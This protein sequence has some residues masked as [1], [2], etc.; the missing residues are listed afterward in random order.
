MLAHADRI[1]IVGMGG[2]FPGSVDVAAF[3]SLVAA[4]RD[5]SADVPE[6]RWAFAPSQVVG[7]PLGTADRVPHARGY[8]LPAFTPQLQGLNLRDWPLAELDPVFQLALHIGNT[9]W[10][11]AK[12]KDVANERCGVIFGNIALPTEQT[13]AITRGVFGPRF[14]LTSLQQPSA[15]NLH[16]AGLPAALLAKALGFGLGGFTLDAA[17]ASSLYAIKLACDELLS[18]RADAMLA[19][20][21]SRPDCLYTQMGFAQLKALSASGRCSPFDAAADGLVVG[22]GGC[23][24]VLKRLAD[25]EAQGDTILGVIAGIGLSNDVEGNL[26][27][28]ASEGQL[29]AMRSAYLQANW[30]PSDV[31]LIECHATGTPTGDAVEFGSLRALWDDQSGRAV[32]GCVKSSVGH[33]LTG[34][35]SAGL[36]KVLLAIKHQTL[37]PTAN[38]KQPSPKMAYANGPFR[39]LQQAE[40]WNATTRRAAVSAFGFGGINAHLLVE[41]YTPTAAATPQISVR[42]GSNTTPIAIVGVA[43]LSGSPLSEL[44]LPLTRFRIPPKELE[45]TLPQQTLML[46]VATDAVADVQSTP[47]DPLALGVF[48]GMTLDPNTSNFHLRWAADEQQP[49]IKDAVH[50][51]LNANR[52]MGALASIAA[53]R[54][55]RLLGAGGPSFSLSD[56]Q[57]GGLRALSLA[58]NALQEGEID[59]AIVGAVDLTTD[60]RWRGT[61]DGAAAVVLKRLADATRDGDRIYGTLGELLPQSQESVPSPN[62]VQGLLDVVTACKTLARQETT[63]NDQPA[64][65]IHD[66]ANGR[67]R[68]AVRSTNVAGFG[69]S[70]EIAE[71]PPRRSAR[72]EQPELASALFT[73]TGDTTEHLLAQMNSRVSLADDTLHG[74]ARQWWQHTKNEPRGKLG[75]AFVA[76][77]FDEYRQAIV[78]AR[79]QLVSNTPKMSDGVC[80]SHQP[81]KGKVAFVYPGSGNHFPDMGRE[82]GRALPHVLHRQMLENQR[83]ASQYHATQVWGVPSLAD[84]SPRDLIFAQ[85]SLGTLVSDL[86]ASFGVKPQAAVGYSLGESASMYGTRAWRDRDEMFERMSVSSLFTSDLAGPCNAARQ[87]WQFGDRDVVDWTTGV[88]HASADKVRAAL[89]PNMRAYLLIINTDTDCVIGGQRA[90]VLEL[91][92]KLNTPLLEVQGVTTAHCEVAQPVRAP[93]RTL[94]HLPTTPPEGVR[95]YSG[96]WGHSYD[97]TADSA[98]DAITAAVLQTIDFPKTVRH[99]YADGARIFIEIGPGQSCTRMIASILDQQPHMVHAACVARQE[100]VAQFLNLL[101]QLHAEGVALNLDV[102]YGQ[103]TPNAPKTGPTLKVPVGYHPHGIAREPQ[104]DVFVP[105]AIPV[106]VAPAG[107]MADALTASVQAHDAFL[108]FTTALQAAFAQSVTWQTALMQQA[109]VADFAHTTPTVV[110]LPTAVPRSLTLEQCNEFAVGK[111]GRVLG[112]LFA[113]IDEHPTRVR[114]PEGPLQLV[115]RIVQIDGEPKSLSHGRVVTEHHVHADRWYLDAGRI[116][117]CVAVEAGQADLFL[118]GFLGIDF[119]TKGLACYRLLDAT[120]TFHRPLP[121]VGETIRYDIHIDSFF[122]QGQ[123]YLFRFHFESTVNGE[124]LLSMREGCA[125]F[126]TAQELASGKGIIHTTLDKKPLPG[127]VP[128][129]WSPYVPLVEQSFSES[130]LDA[131]RQGQLM[132]AFGAEFDRAAL[133][134]PMPLPGGMLKL[135]HRI[136]RILPTGG[137]YGLGQIR[138]EADIHPDDW[139]LTCHFV[140]DQVMPGTLMYECCMHTLRVLLMRMGFVGERGEYVHEPLPGIV[141][142]LKCRGQVIASTK[143][144]TYEVSLKEIGFE[145]SAYVLADALMYADGK[146]IVEIT[147]MS[148]RMTG[149]SRERL[150]AIWHRDPH[151]ALFDT[152]SILAFAIGKPS[153]AFGERYRIFDQERVIARLPGPPY[154]FLDRITSIKHCEPWKLAAG[155]EIIAEYDVPPEEWYFEANRCDKMP[156]SVLLEV[157]LQPCG[158]LAAYLGSALTSTKDLSFRN[159]GGTAT[160]FAEV[161]PDAGTLTTKVKITKVSSSGGMIIQHYDYAVSCA[162][163]PVYV[164]NTYFGFFSKDALANQVGLKDASLMEMGSTELFGWKGPLPTTSPFPNDMLRMVDDIDWCTTA[165]GPQGLGTISGR[166]KVKPDAWFFKAHFH[167]DPVWPGSLGLESF[168]QLLKLFAQRR[169]GKPANG[170]Q[171]VALHRPHQWVYRGQILPTDAEVTVQAYITHIDDATRLVQANGLLSVDGR[172]IYQMTDFAITG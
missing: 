31:S 22:E 71:G 142:R 32:I 150:N 116:P 87:Q 1:A 61:T 9:A 107:T 62:A 65:W 167:Q 112:P 127:V 157:A 21:L 128:T 83:L 159:L 130:Q 134:S 19:G 81:L 164:G 105:S 4:G 96:A 85:V 35:G 160:Q 41:E 86:L 40:P 16:A 63:I 36:A 38:F 147:N 98:A 123:T 12:T 102:L 67:R 114:L 125:G 5:A 52:T 106:P 119:V 58:T 69:L 80:F 155:G 161:R 34:A 20:G 132:R 72:L 46:Q 15:L 97:L 169:L 118:S 44:T 60:E 50:Q 6:R 146:P 92:R 122:R 78:E 101:A 11:S 54:I 49:A 171:A 165:S 91:A 43:S 136:E 30:K 156:F 126:F 166:A 18:G 117:T 88:V 131:L 29:R 53:S 48:I 68:V 143:K 110:E 163:K 99:A 144:V 8:Y 23:A 27:L 73:L 56:E 76:S 103:P 108:R 90:D 168:I 135:V 45:E 28:P 133:Q 139:F 140:D 93:Y 47:G 33:L 70:C 162:G 84:L 10:R 77:T 172:I 145:P 109:S 74:L 26:L 129:G 151:Q 75:L 148:L 124:P 158:W 59:Q 153:E 42:G 7:G 141:S 89:V 57:A 51:P 55:A 14:G 13:N 3:W 111:I 39:V 100:P 149:L 2:I 79:Q 152:N 24:F 66:Q 94:H 138:G 121:Q 64:F 170:W 113:E 95:F 154:K 104:P 17:C 37:P 82:L 115:D 25:A 120:V 137:R